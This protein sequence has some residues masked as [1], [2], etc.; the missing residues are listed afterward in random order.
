VKPHCLAGWNFNTLPRLRIPP[1]ARGPYRHIE[2]AE[3]RDTD[4]LSGHE[5]FE[6]G[7]HYRLHR[8]GCRRLVQCRRLSD[9]VDQFRLVHL[10]RP[11]LV[12]CYETPTSA[13][14]C[15]ANT[16][17]SQQIQGPEGQIFSSPKTAAPVGLPL[18]GRRR[19]SPQLAFLAPLR[20]RY[21]PNRARP[22]LGDLGS[23]SRSPCLSGSGPTRASAQKSTVSPVHQHVIHSL[24]LDC[25]RHSAS[26]LHERK[27][28]LSRES[29]RPKSRDPD[30]FL[31]IDRVGLQGGMG[32]DTG[33]P[34]IRENRSSTLA[35][36]I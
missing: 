13:P 1:V 22:S 27:S 10:G 7:A 20:H 3:A 32:S 28:I 21:P 33:A 15:A 29:C 6:N 26:I 17:G 11:A 18:S 9:F 23:I 35:A 25:D 24:Q 4:C 19:F 31:T 2:S 36:H 5:G 12:H 34:P 16:F 30:G 8:L 14:P